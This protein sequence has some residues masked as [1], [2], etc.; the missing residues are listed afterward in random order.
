[1]S[2]EYDFSMKRHAFVKN[3]RNIRPPKIDKGYVFGVNS[4]VS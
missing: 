2:H 3:S 1:M 4:W